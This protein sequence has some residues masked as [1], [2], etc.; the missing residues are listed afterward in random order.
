MPRIPALLLLPFLLAGIA[1]SQPADG[2]FVRQEAEFRIQSGAVPEASGLAV[3]PEDGRFMWILN[4]SGA[5]PVVHLFNTDGTDRG[6]LEV[7]GVEN[8][9]WEDLA[10]F[11][12]DGR[13]YLLVADTGDNHSKREDCRLHIVEE[14]SLPRDGALLAARLKPAWTIEISY[15]DGPRDCE[16]VAVDA[17]A[18]KIILVSKRTKPPVVY[19]LPLRPEGRGKIIA[20]RLGE[21]AV[22]NPEG[23]FKMPFHEQPTGMSISSD[24]SQAA[25]L[26]YWGVF[27]FPRAKG[28]SWR[29]ALAKPPV[30]LAPHGMAQAEAIAYS[31]DGR[32]LFLVSERGDNRIVTYRR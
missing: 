29:E 22:R 7:E 25:L 24:G 13:S 15:E 26:S 18:G 9:D 23:V 10:A 31:G 16:S 2:G 28:E 27:I 3:S 30:V 17:A 8:V 11:T 12:L 1:R 32:C 20:K 14:P 4:D 5:G 21:T 19:E 6:Q